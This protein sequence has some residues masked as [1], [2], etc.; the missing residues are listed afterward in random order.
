M[1]TIVPFRYLG[2]ATLLAGILVPLD[3]CAQ[4]AGLPARGP[5]PFEIYDVDGDGSISAS[6]FDRVREQRMAGKPGAGKRAPDFARLDSDGDGK[7]S[8]EELESGQGANRS[9]GG[10]GM[11]GRGQN[12]P[13]FGDFDLNGDGSIT[14][15]EFYEARAERTSERAKQG[16]QMKNLGSMPSFEDIDTDSDGVVTAD[17]FA[18]HQSRRRNQ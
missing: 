14:E 17:E 8:R 12:R 9:G 5:I 4:S 2:L 6:E 1:K 18:G 3:S 16:Y 10:A 15:T 7:L 11:G 13:V